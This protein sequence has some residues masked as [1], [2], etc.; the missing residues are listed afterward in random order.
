MDDQNGGT[1][2]IGLGRDSHG[3]LHRSE[4]QHNISAPT[5]VGLRL[6]DVFWAVED[7]RADYEH[8]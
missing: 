2:P 8:Y 7:R 1:K 5:H 6:L 4:N 3:R